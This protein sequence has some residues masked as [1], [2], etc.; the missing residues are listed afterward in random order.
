MNIHDPS[1][2][3]FAAA[4]EYA[5]LGWEVFPVPPGTKKSHKSEKHSGAKWGKTTD[6][7]EI[8]RDFRKW[9][10][11]NVGIATGVASGFFVIECDTIEGHNVDGLKSIQELEAKHGPL[12]ETRMAISPSGSVH[13][14]YRHPG[15]GI[16][17]WNSASQFAPG[18]DIKGDGGMVIAP[19][20]IKPGVGQYRWLNDKP[21]A[22]APAWLIEAA[23]K[24]KEAK[25]PSSRAPSGERAQAKNDF[26]RRHH[27]RADIDLDEIEAALMAIPNDASV[28]WEEWNRIGMAVFAAT[29]GSAAGLAMFDRWSQKY[30]GYDGDDTAAK[31][32]AL[33]Q[34]PP[35]EIGVGTIFYFADQASPA[36]RADY[37]LSSAVSDAIRLDKESDNVDL[38]KQGVD[39][40]D[41]AQ[42]LRGSLAEEYLTSLGLIVPDA[43]HEVL[44][45]HPA[46]PFGNSILPCLVAYVQDCL[47]N[48]PTAVHLTAL[49]PEATPIDCKVVGFIDCYSTI[50]LG[51]E[52]DASGELTI[53]SSIE[54]ALSAMMFGF[55]P[56]WSVLSV[57]G[58]AT[59]PKPRYHNIKRLTVIVDGDDDV[60]AANTCKTRWGS[61]VR[62][63]LPTSKAADL[64]PFELALPAVQQ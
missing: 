57:D 64:F 53:A 60:K 58:I 22:E 28:N 40:F 15:C 21:V 38:I 19:P 6:P 25:K 9:P 23:S 14:Y 4:L 41:H 62:I 36:W 29:C 12:P 27:L 18:V 13:R 34:C 37:R 35:T 8:R 49:S 42:P 39:I 32:D 2:S 47:T 5:A 52:P 3:M 43:A 46:C 54:A 50:K 48:E 16:K 7:G 11:A 26:E 17:I 31:W 44:G 45:F 51:G 59:F 56:V 30:P 1:G 20:S 24:Q 61:L 33:E 10:N 63:A 55:T